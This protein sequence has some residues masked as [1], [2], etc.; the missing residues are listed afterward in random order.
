MAGNICL[1]V[2]TVLFALFLTSSGRAHDLLIGNTVALFALAC[3]IAA[4]FVRPA[5]R[6]YI[7][8]VLLLPWIGFVA[9]QFYLRR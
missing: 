8:V 3:V 2:L 5:Y 4:F 1:G 6:I 7:T 9:W